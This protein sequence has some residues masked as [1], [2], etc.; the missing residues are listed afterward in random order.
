MCSRFKWEGIL[1]EMASAFISSRAPSTANAFFLLLFQNRYERPC[2]A[3]V[4]IR[5][6]TFTGASETLAL[7][8]VQCPGAAYGLA[9][10][11]VGLPEEWQGKNVSFDLGAD[12]NYPEGKGKTMRFKDATLLRQ[13]T[14]FVNNFGRITSVLALL[15][16][17]IH[18]HGPFRVKYTMPDNVATDSATTV[19]E[20]VQ[21]LW[22]TG[23]PLPE[24]WTRSSN[25]TV[26]G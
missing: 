18:I 10:Q 26:H 4:A 6:V 20:Q 23:D 11:E 24:P 2:T 7:I 17:H 22:Q 8:T 15:G 9:K 1:S 25:A 14:H 19:S 3:T 5:P 13:N 12:V 16:G 21:I